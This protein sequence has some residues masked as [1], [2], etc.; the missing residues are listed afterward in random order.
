VAIYTSH[1]DPNGWAGWNDID[2]G[3]KIP[4]MYSIMLLSI[5]MQGGKDFFKKLIARSGVVV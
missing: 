2:D 1:W 4:L 5:V 3:W